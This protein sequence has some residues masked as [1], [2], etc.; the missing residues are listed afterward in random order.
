T[1]YAEGLGDNPSPALAPDQQSLIQAL[2]A[3]G[4]PVI[5]VVIAGRPLGLGPAEQANGLLMAYLPGTEGGAGV[6]DVL[7]GTVN[8]SGKLPATWPSASDHNAGDFQSGGV[9]TA[10]DEPKF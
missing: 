10:G 9:S 6:A 8:P 1:P 2:E 4:K 5:V 3:T 7:F